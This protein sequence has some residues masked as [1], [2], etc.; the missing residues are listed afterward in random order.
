M[1]PN[2]T[3]AVWKCTYEL[4]LFDDNTTKDTGHKLTSQTSLISWQAILDQKKKK[5]GS[6]V[7]WR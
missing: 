4:L 6:F 5:N 2:I 3:V 7:R 1:R